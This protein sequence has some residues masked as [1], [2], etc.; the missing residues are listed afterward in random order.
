VIFAQTSKCSPMECGVPLRR[1]NAQ[2]LPR[3]PSR[4][5]PFLGASRERCNKMLLNG[6]PAC[7]IR[8]AAAVAG[9]GAHNRM[10]CVSPA[11]ACTRPTVTPY[12]AICVGSPP[13]RPAEPVTTRDSKPLKRV[14]G[15]RWPG[16]GG[17]CENYGLGCRHAPA[18]QV[19][20]PAA[21]TN[22]V[23]V[24]HR[25][26]VQIDAPVTLAGRDHAAAHGVPPAGDRDRSPPQRARL[27]RETHGPG[28]RLAT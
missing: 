10:I 3:R 24:D 14:P 26:Y 20:V 28:D 15:N 4:E 18:G 27:R 9:H 8:L 5:P 13:A 21:V 25:P 11:S 12:P 6:K 22:V 17:S 7:G 19:P 1:L 16:A 2:L 23:A